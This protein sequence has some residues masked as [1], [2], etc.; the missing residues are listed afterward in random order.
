MFTISVLRNEFRPVLIMDKTAGPS[1]KTLTRWIAER[2][3]IFTTFNSCFV[4]F[5]QL[6][7]Q[8]RLF[9]IASSEFLRL[10]FALLFKSVSKMYVMKQTNMFAPSHISHECQLYGHEG[11]NKT[12]LLGILYIETHLNSPCSCYNEA[13]IIV[14]LIFKCTYQKH[15]ISRAT[16]IAEVWMN[17]NEQPKPLQ[18]WRQLVFL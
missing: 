17:L 5:S 10:W 3:N 15:S 8:L 4:M 13:C 2:V 1:H 11:Q 6:F 7:C 12:T 9:V 18:K 14:Q 16:S